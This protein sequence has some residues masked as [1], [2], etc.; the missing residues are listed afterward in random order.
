MSV[1]RLLILTISFYGLVRA[2]VAREQI[3][4]S[5]QVA[6]VKQV[7]QYDPNFPGKI[8]SELRLCTVMQQISL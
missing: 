2:S 7:F 4:L 5:L 6:I 3:S 8:L 1:V